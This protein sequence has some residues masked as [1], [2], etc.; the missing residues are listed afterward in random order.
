MGTETAFRRALVALVLGAAALVAACDGFPF[1]TGCAGVGYSAVTVTVRDQLGH[2]QALG[3]TVM[4][5]DGSY[6][7]T[8]APEDSLTVYGADDRGG[9]TYDIHVTKPFYNEVWVRGVR[10]PGGGCVTGH[11]SSPTNIAVPIVLSLAPNAP[12]TRSIHLLPQ[13]TPIL[14]RGRQT[15]LTFATIIDVDPGVSRAVTWSMTGDTASV[16][17]DPATGLLTYRCLATSGHV[18]VTAT[19]TANPSISGSADLA[20]QGHPAG[21]GDPPC[22]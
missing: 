6:A 13:Y 14:D 22:N 5:Q 21:S 15:T 17:L 1:E 20:V 10:A 11:E 4:L 7:E 19:L 2:P 16:G 8:H 18:T 12:P 9:R 3:A